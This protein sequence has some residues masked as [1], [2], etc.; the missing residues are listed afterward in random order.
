MSIS[1]RAEQLG[2]SMGS[3]GPQALFDQLEELLPEG[4]REQIAAFPITA[5][6]VGFGLGI[7]LG[8]K[9]GDELLAAGSTMLA[10]AATANLS[11]VLGQTD[12]G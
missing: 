12:Q 6:A 2:S 7:F 5:L 10:A 1:D 9:K 3:E 11:E 8:M 4:W